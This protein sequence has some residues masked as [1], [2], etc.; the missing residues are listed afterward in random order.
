[1]FKNIKSKKIKYWLF[2]HTHYDI[3]DKINDIK[4]ICNPRGRP[5]DFNRENYNLKSFTI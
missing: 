3:N 5:D 1:M 2:G 4:Y